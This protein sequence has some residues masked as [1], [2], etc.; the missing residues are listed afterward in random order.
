M[1]VTKGY[2]P[3]YF[4]RSVAAGK[5]N[6]YTAAAEAGMEPAGHWEGKGLE[7][8]GL[9]AGSVVDPDTLRNLFTKRIHPISH[10][11]SSARRTA[12]V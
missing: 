6:Y 12:W 10:K 4:L 11:E 5:E 8:L 9:E 1:S 7:A 2:D 3:G